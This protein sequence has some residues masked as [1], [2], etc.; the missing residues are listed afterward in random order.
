MVFRSRVTRTMRIARPS[1]TIIPNDR[2]CGK[3]RCIESDYVAC[4]TTTHEIR[5]I[6]IAIDR[7]FRL[8]R[9]LG[10]ALG[11][12]YRLSPGRWSL[13]HTRIRFIGFSICAQTS[14]STEYGVFPCL[15]MISTILPNIAVGDKSK[16]QLPRHGHYAWKTPRILLSSAT[17]AVR[18]VTGSATT[19]TQASA[20]PILAAY[21]TGFLRHN[22]YAAATAMKV[23]PNPM[24][25]YS[26]VIFCQKLR[27]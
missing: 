21:M 7:L 26:H 20:R 24:A 23:M 14:R 8:L 10:I 5:K 25:R 13:R 2:I 6:F 9:A 16:H 18:G 4:L 27:R 19:V 3:E 17:P 22:V 1:A 15:F 12:K 11:I